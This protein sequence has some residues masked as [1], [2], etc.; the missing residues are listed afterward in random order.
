MEI[1]QNSISSLNFQQIT[2]RTNQ[3]TDQ[4]TSFTH[5]GLCSWKFVAHPRFSPLAPRREP[6]ARLPR[7]RAQPVCR[8]RP[9]RGHGGR[10]GRASA[11]NER[12]E[13]EN[14]RKMSAL[15]VPKL[16]M[17]SIL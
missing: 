13:C 5:F 9:L 8:G 16:L 12:E 6:L 7:A 10:G 4:S 14:E 1:A 11:K 17:T 3:Q 2:N 15:V